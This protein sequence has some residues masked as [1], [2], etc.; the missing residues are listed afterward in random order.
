MR[1]LLQ[2]VIPLSSLRPVQNC[3]WRLA[4]GWVQARFRLATGWLPA[5]CEGFVFFLRVLGFYQL[6]VWMGASRHPAHSQVQKHLKILGTAKPAKFFLYIHGRKSVHAT[7]T[8]VDDAAKNPCLDM[9]ITLSTF[10]LFVA[11]RI[12]DQSWTKNIVLCQ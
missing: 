8:G 1:N 4:V 5:G 11:F 3:G 9:T 7:Y 12:Y 2:H 6:L 10:Y